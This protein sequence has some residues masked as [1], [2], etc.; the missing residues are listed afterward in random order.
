MSVTVIPIVIG[1]LEESSKAWKRW[2]EEFGN[3][4]TNQDHP[5]NSIVKIGPHTGNV[6]R[7]VV[8]Q[9][10]VK[11]PQLMLAWKTQEK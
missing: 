4:R 6:M 10:P 7:L 2:V 5:N 8:T 11:D 3:R 9:N 1:A